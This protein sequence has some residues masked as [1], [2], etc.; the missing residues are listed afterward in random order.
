MAPG[1]GQPPLPRAIGID[2]VETTGARISLALEDE[3]LS[4]GRPGRIDVEEELTLASERPR[5]KDDRRHHGNDRGEESHH[6]W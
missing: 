1:P 4:V 5:I 2:H 3:L 6:R